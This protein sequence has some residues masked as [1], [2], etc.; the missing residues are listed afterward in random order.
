M[1]VGQLRTYL[2]EVERFGIL[3]RSIWTMRSVLQQLTLQQRVQESF[4]GHCR[5]ALLLC[6]H[7][8]FSLCSTLCCSLDNVLVTVAAACCSTP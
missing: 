6:Q 7:I 8:C 5:G 2:C 1:A 3:R 4:F